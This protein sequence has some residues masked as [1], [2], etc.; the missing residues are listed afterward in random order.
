MVLDL[1]NITIQFGGLVAVN[2]VSL[3]VGE[4]EI[5]GLIGPNG[6]GKTTVFN[7]I[8]GI[9]QLNSGR[10]C[11]KGKDITRVKPD[12]RT[13]LGIARTFQNIRL[14]KQ[15]TVTDNLII[16]MHHLRKITFVESLLRLP[17]YFSEKK[18]T[19]KESPAMYPPPDR[20]SVV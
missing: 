11:F 4:K 20:K 13:R 16:A 19:I 14:F 9:Y 1:E 12:M 8:T 5:V 15:L 2:D 18:R 3:S 7:L 17:T 10:I 6:A